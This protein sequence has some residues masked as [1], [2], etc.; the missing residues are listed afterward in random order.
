M[1]AVSRGVYQKVCEEN[2]RLKADIKKLVMSYES[3]PEYLETLLKWRKCF[4]N[5]DAFNILMREA[6]TQYLK[7]HP[8]IKM[9]M[10]NFKQL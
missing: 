9:H 10:P 4:K 2:K 7:E 8:E 3:A 5:E 1:S 6:G